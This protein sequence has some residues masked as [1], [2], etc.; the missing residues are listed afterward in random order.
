MEELNVSH[1]VKKLAGF[2]G[3]RRLLAT[4]AKACPCCDSNQTS[5]SF[6]IT[7]LENAF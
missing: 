3:N 6:H 5:P 7:H 1:L 2:Y 4:F